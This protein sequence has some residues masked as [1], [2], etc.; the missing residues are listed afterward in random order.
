MEDLPGDKDSLRALCETFI[1][2][3]DELETLY[4]TEKNKLKSIFSK[5]II[6]VRIQYDR[7][8]SNIQRRT[9]FWGSTNEFEFLNDLTGNVRWLIF[10]LKADAHPIDFNYSKNIDINR[11]WAQAYYI[12][13]QGKQV[14]DYNLSLAEIKENDRAN[15][16]HMIFPPEY[17]LI[18]ENYSP[19]EATDKEAEFFTAT[20]FVNDCARRVNGSIKLNPERMGRVLRK[21]GFKRVNGYKNK[22][23][24]QITDY[25]VRGYYFKVNPD[26][27]LQFNAM[28]KN[29]DYGKD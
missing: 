27:I 3:L 11:V 14:F 2:N 15:E 22:N 19:A 26:H 13:K 21:L 4:K 25:Q 20:D 5:D 8:F 7:K 9:N 24:K 18:K 6:N 1:L 12:F 16:Q 28:H 23:G 29:S 17:D 10:T